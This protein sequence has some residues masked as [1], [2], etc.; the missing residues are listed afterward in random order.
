MTMLTVLQF[1]SP[2]LA[3]LDRMLGEGR[4]PVLAG[5]RGRG[6]WHELD[7][8]ATHFAAGA[9]HTLYSG[10]ELGDHGLF[11][12]FQWSAADQRVRYTTAFPA[13]APVWER[14][15][16]HSLAMDPYESRPPLTPPS[17]TVISGWQFT[18]RVVLQPWSSPPGYNA[19]LERLFGPPAA[20]EEV[21][22][23]SAARDLLTLRRDL[24]AASGRAADAAR[25][26]LAR[27]HYDLAWLTFS[28]GHVAG[29]QFWDDSQLGDDADV[30]TR[31]VLNGA[32]EE[33]Y[34][35]VDA[36]FGRVLEALPEGADVIVTSPVGMDVNTSRADLL[37]EMLT[38]VLSGGAVASD[39]TGSGFVWKLRAA[40]PTGLRAQVASALPDKV[41][42][43]LT[44]RLELRGQDWSTTRAFAQPA[45]NQG[46]VRL[47]LAGRERDGIVAAAEAEAL[48]DEIASGLMTFTDPDGTPSVK[49]VERVADTFP[50]GV[51][52]DRLPELIVRWADTPATR[53]THVRSDRFGQVARRGAGSGRSGNHT[54]GDAWALVVPGASTVRETS[55]P[56]RLVDIAATAG[57]LAGLDPAVLPGEPL[58]TR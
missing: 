11:Y 44:E 18:D 20:V 39:D 21:F 2:S 42:L 41:A 17:G 6:T 38:A 8:P 23:R 30:A 55:R 58:L 26:L 34:Q 32:L 5:L 40:L 53:I 45:D 3:V 25:L 24:L 22:G 54:A 4:L 7:T 14:L 31:H 13:P 15:S 10:T 35:S 9:F 50:A 28:A 47:N 16:T 56:P 48:M 19:K 43:A 29:H 1:D 51:H 46:Y 37:P 52:S 27:E 49:A 12:P 33:I 57:A 36:A